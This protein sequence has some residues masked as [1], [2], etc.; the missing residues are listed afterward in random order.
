MYAN[1]QD[2]FRAI[3]KAFKD[4]THVNFSGAYKLSDDPLVSDN[5]RVRMTIHDIWKVTGYRFT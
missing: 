2:L 3:R 5:E 4:D 1:S